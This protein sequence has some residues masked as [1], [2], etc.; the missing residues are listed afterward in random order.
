MLD[1]VDRL[2]E[3]LTALGPTTLYLLTGLFM[4]M[5][6]VVFIGMVVPGDS[7][8]L[9]A[10]TTADDP[11][12]F[13]ALASA[14]A[15]GSLAGESLGYVIGRHYGERLRHS[16]AGRRLGDSWT[17]AEAFL[18]GR[19][20]RSLV[21]VRFVAVAHAVTPIIAGSARMPYRRFIGWSAIGA[22][23]WSTL[24]TAIGA[25]AGASWREYGDRLGYFGYALL[26]LVIG[27]VV[28]LK[29][30]GRRRRRSRRDPSGTTGADRGARPHGRA[31]DHDREAWQQGQGSGGD[32]GPAR[33]AER[34][35]G[36]S[37]R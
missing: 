14:G 33:E 7:V 5:E 9:L 20:G 3:A 32:R 30:A 35:S 13:M 12:S 37:R 28:V 15:L 1:L 23:V 2:L 36:P 10:G 8:M 11:R 19:G 16:R 6:T 21:A 4:V 24:Y 29:I 17:R 34:A 25:A 27:T 31:D 18:N 22:V 26:A